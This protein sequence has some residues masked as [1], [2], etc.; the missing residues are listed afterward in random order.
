MRCDLDLFPQA[1]T[2]CG[3]HDLM[4]KPGQDELTIL[5]HRSG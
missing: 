3:K 4:G 2:Y 1:M 5:T